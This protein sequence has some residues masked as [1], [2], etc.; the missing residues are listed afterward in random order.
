MRVQQGCKL[1]AHA[2][3]GL[4]LARCEPM[5][6]REYLGSLREHLGPPAV[7]VVAAAAAGKYVS[8][9]AGAVVTESAR[10]HS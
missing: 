5:S 3:R 8:K 2:S 4:Q 1:A 6:W 10:A 7:V 9:E